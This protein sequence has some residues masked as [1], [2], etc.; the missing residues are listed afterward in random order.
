MFERFDRFPDAFRGDLPAYRFR[1]TRGRSRQD[2]R[3]I[4]RRAGSAAIVVASVVGAVAA[5][6]IVGGAAAGT[7]SSC[8]RLIDTGRRDRWPRG[9]WF[10]RWN[11]LWLRG[12]TV[13]RTMTR[14]SLDDRITRSFISL[15]RSFPRTRNFAREAVNV[16]NVYF[17]KTPSK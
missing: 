10:A 9:W 11:G 7:G 14:R 15:G 13:A 8:G 17:H 12:T 2:A 6:I 3:V 5:V 4:G 1:L 16:F